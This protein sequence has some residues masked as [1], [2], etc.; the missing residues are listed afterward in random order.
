MITNRQKQ[1]VQETFTL[2]AP[3]ADTA[4]SL[5]YGRLFELDPSLSRMFRGDMAE[6]GRKLM[7]M[8]GLAVK[9]LDR[10]EVLVP[11]VEALG[12]RHAGYGVR[13]EHYGTVASALLWTLKTG[14]GD[15]FTLEV[16]E[17][18]TAVYVLLAETM[19]QGANKAERAAAVTV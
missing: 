4:A 6:Q 11:A 10:L 2:V 9:G 12:A 14:L 15:A 13:D 19:Q 17:A 3:I 5:F 16:E 18:W 1:L 7:T 8:I